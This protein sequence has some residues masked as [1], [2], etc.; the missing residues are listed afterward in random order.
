M[1]FNSTSSARADPLEHRE[2]AISPL[3]LW[4]RGF[5][6]DRAGVEDALSR[7]RTFC[8]SATPPHPQPASS[9]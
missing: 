7:L 4:P 5:K 9:L 3:Q 8:A 6:R 2:L 1:C